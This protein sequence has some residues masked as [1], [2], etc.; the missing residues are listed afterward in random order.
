MSSQ[1]VENLHLR[2]IEQRNQLHRTTSE[3]KAKISE[4]REQFDL[5]HNIRRHLAGAAAILAA[6]GLLSGYGVGG[7]LTHH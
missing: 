2:A 7:M 5:S 3:L 4:T 6:I 1:P